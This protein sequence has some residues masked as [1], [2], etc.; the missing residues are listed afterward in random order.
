MSQIIIKGAR[1]NNLKNI[2]ITIPRGKVV[3]F[4]GVSGSGKSTIAFDIIAKEGQR[5]YFESLSAYARRYLAKSNRPEIDDIKGISSAV[6]I[7]QD[8]L[9]HN[10]RSTV[11]T[12]TEAYTYLRLLYSRVGWPPMDSSH[13]SFNHSDGFCLRCKGLGRAMEIDLATLVDFAKSLNQGAI[14]YS[15]WR[16]G[17]MM[18]KIIRAT[19]YFDMDKKVGDF[20]PEELDKLLYAKKESLGDRVGQGVICPTYKGVITHLKSRGSSV[21]RAVSEIEKRYFKYQDCPECRGWRLKKEA[22]AVKIDG[23]NIGEVARLP[24]GECLEFVQKIDHPH[25]AVIRPRLEAQLRHLINAGVGYLALDRGTDTLS[26]GESQRV[27][28]ARQL[29]CDLTETIYVLDEP[30]AGLHPRDVGRVIENLR[31]LR[32]GG[33]TVLVVEHDEAVIRAAD[34]LVEVGPGGGRKG[35]K[36]VCQGKPDQVLAEPKSVTGRFLEK[37]GFGIFSQAGPALGFP[38]GKPARGP[39][40]GGPPAQATRPEGK[41][42]SEVETGQVN[43]RDWGVLTSEVGG[44][45]KLVIRNARLHNLKGFDLAI[46]TGKL[47]ALTGVSGSGKSSLTEEIKAQHPEKVVV[48][49]QTSIGANRRGCIATYVGVFDLVRKLFAEASSQGV[50]LFSYNSKGA[51]PE[52]E[53]VGYLNLDMNFLGDIKVRCTACGGKRYCPEALEFR[54]QGKNAAEVLAMPVEEAAAFFDQEEIN[55]KLELLV[56]VGLDYIE[57]GQSLDTLSGG[58]SQRLKLVSR[59]QARGEFYI[60]DEPTSGLHPADVEKLLALLNRLVYQGNTVLVVEH[61]LNLIARADWVID[62]GPEGGEAGG[63]VVAQGRP[64]EV[65]R[66]SQ[67]MTGRFLAGNW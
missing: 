32:E 52:C 16:V 35:G 25:A 20:S 56:E 15:N 2:D 11:G 21:S 67:S 57:L 50:G 29:G 19:G 53:G 26:G 34:Y 36:I 3:C 12:V 33:N 45:E 31:A 27:K 38:P 17:S 18:W 59:L 44:Y 22:L 46:P 40:P 48:V 66:D 61:N 62:L 64:E 10:P 39:L 7:S 6:V 47:V 13:Y 9:G 1:E 42:N 24:L 14:L 28:M 49:D 54:Y 5:Q 63:E 60:L 51:C 58:E 30:T 43:L 37:A 41:D 23:K 8:R 4:V 55:K 65:A